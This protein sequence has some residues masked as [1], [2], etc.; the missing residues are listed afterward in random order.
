MELARRLDGVRPSGTKA[1]TQRAAA[2]RA[3]GRNV[4]TLSQGE[5]D[6]ETPAPIRAAGIRAIEAGRTRYTPVAGVLELRRAIRQ[7]LLQENDLSY[8]EDEIIVGCGAK[9]VIFN[10]LFATL[11]PGD[12]VIIPTPCWVSYPDVVE[13]ASGHPVLVA[14]PETDS[15]KLTPQALQAAITPRSR[16]LMLNSPCN[17]TGAVYSAGELRA[18]A[19]VLRRFPGILLLSD[20]IYEKLVFG[21]VKFA[22][23]AAEAPDLRDRILVINGLSKTNAMT[24]WRVGYGA[25]PLPLIKAMNTIQGQTTSH[26]SSVS[27][28]AAIEALLGDQDYVAEFVDV[29]RERR[30]L[31]VDGLNRSP[32][33]ECGTPDGAFY[34]FASCQGVIGKR[35]PAGRMMASDADFADY[36]LDHVGVAL[37]PGSS[38]MASPYVRLSYAASNEDL[39]EAC[40]RIQRA[41]Q[42]LG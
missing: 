3:Q 9:Q 12:E 11:N 19:D 23:M 41:C 8:D 14:C 33:L 29:L 38:F 15:F 40:V 26:T 28:Y 37:V 25:G 10:A 17:P 18:L 22:T 6:F 13:L 35:T 27:Q 21:A 39:Q 31:V 36:L 16:W 32:G 4:I 24:G 42:D 2:L 5:L 20:D 1:M 7:K 34:V 30:D